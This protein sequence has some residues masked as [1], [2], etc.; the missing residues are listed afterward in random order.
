MLSP[1]LPRIGGVVVNHLHHVLAF[2]EQL[3]LQITAC[4]E[5][6]I[7][8]GDQQR[9]QQCTHCR[10]AMAYQAAVIVGVRCSAPEPQEDKRADNRNAHFGEAIDDHVA[11]R[12]FH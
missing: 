4:V 10:F 7:W 11:E 3:E 8:R 2:A 1:Q 12:A 9:A 5:R 6:A